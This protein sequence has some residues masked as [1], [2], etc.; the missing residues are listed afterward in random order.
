MPKMPKMELAGALKQ[1]S[2]V[3]EPTSPLLRGEGQVW[4]VAAPAMGLYVFAGHAKH[5]EK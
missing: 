3:V 2:T 5:A 1:F 4:Q